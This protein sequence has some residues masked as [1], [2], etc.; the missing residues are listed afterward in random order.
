MSKKARS[1]APQK[2][3]VPARS[4]RSRSSRGGGGVAL[5]KQAAAYMQL[6]ADPCNADLVTAPFA[7]GHAGYLLR[8]KQFYMAGNNGSAVDSYS[9]FVPGGDS[10]TTVSTGMWHFGYAAAPGGAMGTLGGGEG[11][12]FLSSAAVGYYR[13]VAGCIKVHYTGSELNR[14]GMVTLGL[15]PKLNLAS[16]EP[17]IPGVSQFVGSGFKTCRLGSQPHELRYVPLSA[18]DMNFSSATQPLSGGTY[19]D[20]TT[21]VVLV[22]GAPAG[23][24]RLEVDFVWEWTP[25]VGSGLQVTIEAPKSTNTINEVLSKAAAVYGSLQAFAVSN[26]GKSI[27]TGIMNTIS[28][29]RN[30]G[31]LALLA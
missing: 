10:N 22:E 8:T 24:I 17:G 5:D 13:P 30:V 29:A 7:V 18:A 14:Q 19:I 11:P 6:L 25:D 21:L 9:A 2:Q 16:G 23:T 12:A 3:R 28:A 20:A 26:T 31:G 15:L 4:A 27:V 1:K